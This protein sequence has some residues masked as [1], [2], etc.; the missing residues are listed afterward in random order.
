MY[1]EKFNNYNALLVKHY[2]AGLSP[3]TRIQSSDVILLTQIHIEKQIKP[4]HTTSRHLYITLVT[5]STFIYK[6]HTHFTELQ[7]HKQNLFALWVDTQRK[8]CILQSPSDNTE[9]KN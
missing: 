4:H 8:E 6:N 7:I 1:N 2:I 9:V 5:Q 3:V